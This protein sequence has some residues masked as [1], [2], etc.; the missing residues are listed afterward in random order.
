MGIYQFY[1]IDADIGSGSFATVKRAIHRASGTW[2]AVK[3]IQRKHRQD[4]QNE[5]FARETTVMEQLKHPNIVMMKD[6]FFEEDGCISEYLY[7][8]SR[9]YANAVFR[10]RHGVDGRW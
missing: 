7:V 5:A 4:S 9:L 1:D 8:D 2:Y 3:I 10:H 6:T